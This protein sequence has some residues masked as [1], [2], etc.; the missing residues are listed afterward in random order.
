MTAF[1]G[2][3]VAY[4]I[5]PHGITFNAPVKIQ[6]T[7]AGTWAQQYPQLLKGIHGSYFA[8]SLDS[9]WVDPGHYFARIAENELAYPDVN[10][11]QVKFYIGHFSGYMMSCGRE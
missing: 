10:A 7:I 5:Q 3:D 4:D 11:S 2:F 6:Q 8:G 9:A 1:K